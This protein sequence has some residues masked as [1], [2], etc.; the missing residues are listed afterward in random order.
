LFASKKRLFAKISFRKLAMD[1][2]EEID[3][4]EDGDE[5][6]Y[7]ENDAKDGKP[8]SDMD[9]I[10][11]HVL[12]DHFNKST[13]APLHQAQKQKSSVDESSSESESES[14][15]DESAEEDH[16]EDDDADADD[17]G[18]D[19][20]KIDIDALFNVNDESGSMQIT[21]GGKIRMKTKQ[22]ISKAITMLTAEEEQGLGDGTGILS[23]KNEL[24]EPD[25]E[26]SMTGADIDITTEDITKLVCIGR[27]H[28]TT[29]VVGEP[30]IIVVMSD[31]TTSPLYEGSLLLSKN[32]IKLGRIHEVFGPVTQPC[33]MIRQRLDTLPENWQTEFVKGG[34]VYCSPQLEST[35]FVSPDMI[36][37][38]R[39]ASKATD[40]S[41]IFDEE[42]PEDEQDFS[43][44]EAEKAAKAA[45]KR[46]KNASRATGAGGGNK[47][48]VARSESTMAVAP[49]PP[50][51]PQQHY[52]QQHQH[53][54]YQQFPPQM[55]AGNYFNQAPH[56][57]YTQQQMQY[58][59][60]PPHPQYQQQHLYQQQ[61]PQPQYQPQYQQPQGFAP[62]WAGFAGQPQ[63]QHPTQQ[64]YMPGTNQG[65]PSMFN[66]GKQNHQQPQQQQQ[67]Q[68]QHAPQYTYKPLNR[69]M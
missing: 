52:N 2:S 34:F 31:V 57:A 47:I 25:V 13:L 67:Q 56:F 30:V 3:I 29:A 54:Q 32:G 11:T 20:E 62:P 69:Y 6:V 7:L 65:E 14:D 4:F 43:D 45:K 9:F 51:P 66:L 12:A 5:V 48:R 61:Q 16:L 21:G 63:Q 10:S 22:K 38:I 58:Q 19:D 60:P 33:Y 27:V 37:S 17:E 28:M 35:S 15:S 64:P 53:Q 40:A 59:Q 42:L 26:P 50:P 24:P 55:A 49:P 1:P 39:N 46:E 18:E 36:R 68:Q 41:N 44:D 23:T 8:M